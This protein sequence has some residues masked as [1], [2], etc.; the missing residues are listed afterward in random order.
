MIKCNFFYYCFIY[1]IISIFSVSYA[2]KTNENWV[3]VASEE[4]KITYINI[5]GLSNFQG[6]DIY[7]WSLEEFNPAVIMDESVGKIYKAKTYYLFNKEQKRYSIMQVILYDK[8]DNVLK[9]FSYNRNMDLP[10]LKYSQPIIANSDAD[11]IFMKCMEIISS[12]N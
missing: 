2:Q 11:K 3:P 12:T 10:E 4:G 9:S 1:I 6:E 5:T 8:N 7:I